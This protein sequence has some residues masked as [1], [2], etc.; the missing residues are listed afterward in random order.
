MDDIDR[1]Q[2][3]IEKH[4]PKPQ[5]YELPEG[6]PGECELCGS[7]FGRLVQGACAPCREK[8]RLG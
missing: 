4:E 6:K 7:W 5:P 3:Y 8:Y 2:D 1:A